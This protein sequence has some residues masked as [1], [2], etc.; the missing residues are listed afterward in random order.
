MT[1]TIRSFLAVDIDDLS[2]LRKISQVKSMLNKTGAD[3]KVV[4]DQNIHLT[5]YTDIY[6]LLYTKLLS[7]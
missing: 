6:N 1:E 7:T 2:I 3:L 5:L 4:Q